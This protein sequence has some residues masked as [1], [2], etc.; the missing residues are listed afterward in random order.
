MS[1]EDPYDFIPQ[2]WIKIRDF[3]VAAIDISLEEGDEKEAIQKML[4][5]EQVIYAQC[6]EKYDFNG[7]IE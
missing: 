5:L 7:L 2:N 1:E 4:L 3:L 6:A